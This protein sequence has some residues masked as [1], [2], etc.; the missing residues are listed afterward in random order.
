MSIHV[1]LPGVVGISDVNE[2]TLMVVSPASS[3][4]TLT[5]PAD[6]VVCSIVDFI[7]VFEHVLLCGEWAWFDECPN[8]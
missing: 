1:M 3:V 5:Y 8:N 6:W 7:C 4:A 2:R